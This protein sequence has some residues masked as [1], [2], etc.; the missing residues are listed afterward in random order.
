MALSRVVGVTRRKP[1]QNFLGKSVSLRL[2]SFS[3]RCL[4]IGQQA[5]LSLSSTTYKS[6]HYKKTANRDF[7][8]FRPKL[9]LNLSRDW[10]GFY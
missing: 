4:L 9:V 3:L 5:G 6:R 8:A 7:L 2:V 1:L 10:D